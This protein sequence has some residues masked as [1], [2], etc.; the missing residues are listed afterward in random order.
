LSNTNKDI[1]YNFVYD[2]KQF[3]KLRLALLVVFSAF[4][5][6]I[7]AILFN[8]KEIDWSS[9]LWLCFGG[10]LVTISSNGFN[11]IFEKNLDKLM[12]RTK[13]RPLPTERM[14]LTVAWTITLTSGII[15]A[16]ILW[17]KLNPLTG[18]LGISSLILY[19]FVYTPMKQK[20]AWAV[21]VG[22]F[23]GAAPP[24]IGWVA[25]EAVNQIWISPAALSVFCIQFIWQFPHFWAIAWRCH[26]DYKKGGFQLLPSQGGKDSKSAFQI[27][28]YTLFMVPIAML[29]C[30]PDFGIAGFTSSIIVLTLGIIMLYPAIMLMKT[31]E[32]KWATKLM[33]ASFIYLPL[34]L[35]T[36]LTDQFY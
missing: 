15:G 11:Q 22:A 14:S 26:D 13:N 29:P 27:L 12:S 1:S 32:E 30:H 17:I 31:L 19:S 20:T 10:M 2:L 25:C 16:L 33:F 24:L 28:I 6:Y 34:V 3:T 36:F 18:I 23:P 9:V 8:N 21:F 35:I 7:T 4:I 5:T